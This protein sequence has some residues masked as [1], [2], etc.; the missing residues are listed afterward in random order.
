MQ[1]KEGPGWKAC[2]DEK[3]NLYMAE[4]SWRGFYQLCEIDRETYNRLGTDAMGDRRPGELIGRGRVLVESDDDYYTC[5][6]LTVYDKN[7]LE[8]APW[9]DARRRAEALA[10]W[11]ASHGI[12]PSK[13]EN[14]GDGEKKRREKEK[15]QG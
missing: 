8:L 12:S 4:R 15:K 10:A 6:Y 7:Y 3:R 9:A 5:P 2:Y 1:F 11:E 14:C 13:A